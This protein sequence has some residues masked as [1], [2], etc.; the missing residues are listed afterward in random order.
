M[1]NE[2]ASMD[3]VADGRAQR[4]D[5]GSGHPQLDS[6][7]LQL[8]MLRPLCPTLIRPWIQLGVAWYYNGFIDPEPPCSEKPSR[9]RLSDVRLQTQGL[10]PLF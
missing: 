4:K 8:Q 3:A 2:A 6:A 1:I 5:L 10:V 9:L 7:M